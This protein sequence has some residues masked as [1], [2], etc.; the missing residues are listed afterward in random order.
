M[1]HKR[2][3]PLRLVASKRQHDLIVG[4][5]WY[6]ASEWASTK[7]NAT[8]QEMFEETYEEWLQV[9]EEALKEFRAQGLNV[10][11]SFITSENFL[12]G[13]YWRAVYRTKRPLVGVNNGVSPL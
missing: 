12:V 2:K 7:A 1:K 9:A 6:T 5:V 13:A 8:D 11:R 4:V 3:L 10:Q